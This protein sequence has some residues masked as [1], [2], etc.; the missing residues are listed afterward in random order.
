MIRL[1]LAVFAL[2]FFGGVGAF[3]LF[4]PPLLIAAVW[5]ALVAL[6]LAALAFTS[7]FSR[8]RHRTI[9]TGRFDHV[10][11]H[12]R[13]RLPASASLLARIPKQQQNASAHNLS[14]AVPYVPQ[15]MKSRQYPRR[16]R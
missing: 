7:S 1:V 8:G 16:K 11:S 14:R 3:F 5:I 6:P 9:S 10:R 13:I 12:D 15:L 4:V 2:L